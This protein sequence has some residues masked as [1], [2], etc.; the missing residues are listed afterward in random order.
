MAKRLISIKALPVINSFTIND[1]SVQTTLLDFI[2]VMSHR[3]IYGGYDTYHLDTKGPH[4]G[5][6]EGHPLIGFFC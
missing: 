6:I 2:Q 4:M 1:D 3:N 5:D